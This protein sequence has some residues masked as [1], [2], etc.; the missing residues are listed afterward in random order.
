MEEKK[1]MTEKFT[2]L[3]IG[4]RFMARRKDWI[5]VV[6]RRDESGNVLNAAKIQDDGR[7][8]RSLAAEAELDRIEDSETVESLRGEPDQGYLRRGQ[9]PL[10]WMGPRFQTMKRG[11]SA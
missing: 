1:T 5:K 2:A 11:A 10:R 6:P 4:D 9:L 8:C 3:S 7:I